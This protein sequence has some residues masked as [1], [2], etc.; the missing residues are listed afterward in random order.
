MAASQDDDVRISE[1]GPPLALEELL[2]FERTVGAVLP[3][4]LRNMLLAHNG[5]RPTPKTF[6]VKGHPEGLFDIQLFFGITG[7]IECENIDWNLREFRE[8]TDKRLIPFARTDTGDLLL[9]D[10]HDGSV[11]FWDA[12]EEDPGQRCYRIADSHAGFLDS[13]RSED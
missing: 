2:Q 12:L 4:S 5:G 1:P 13:L 6:E 10:L 3:E 9:I 8:L 11:V 7:E